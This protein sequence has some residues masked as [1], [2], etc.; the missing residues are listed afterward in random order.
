M[1]NASKALLIAG[2][3][4]I[5][6]ILASLVLMV[7][8]NVAEFYA[9]QDELKMTADKAKFN[10]QFTRFNREDVQGYELISLANMVIDYNE[11]ISSATSEGNDVQADPVT[12]KI[13]LWDGVSTREDEIK[14]NFAYDDE[15]RL[16]INRNLIEDENLNKNNGASLKSMLDNINKI[17]KNYPKIQVLTKR[18]SSIFILKLNDVRG[19]THPA[20][21][22]LLVFS[23][24]E[25]KIIEYNRQNMISA[26]SAMNAALGTEKYKV[27]DSATV[28]EV[29]E[30]YCKFANPS[31]LSS[32]LTR[33]KKAEAEEQ[34]K[35]IYQYYEYTQFKKAKFKCTKLHYND[36]TGKVDEINFLCTGEIE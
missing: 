11:R 29:Y 7:K 21:K 1:E 4:L 2:G 26:I 18:I 17:E 6:I 22:V 32:G 28:S 34:K 25:K 3:I 10:E 27:P 15:L 36:T 14:R 24:E 35:A 19:Y 5:V 9:S 13:V 8:A 23:E 30:V 20:E 33:E 16:F 31:D 12:I